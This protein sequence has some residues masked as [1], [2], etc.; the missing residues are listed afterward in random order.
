MNFQTMNKQRKWTLIAAAAGI[1]SIMLPFATVS[2]N[3]LGIESSQST[4][5]FH[6]YGIGVLLGYL[7]AIVLSLNGKQ[8]E[9]MQKSQWL[10][11]LAAGFI[12]LLFTVISMSIASKSVDGG[13]GLVDA[14]IG[15]GAWISLV[16]SV[17]L[18][19]SNW[20]NRQPEHEIKSSF[21]ELKKNFSGLSSPASTPAS[22]ATGIKIAE[23]ERLS[24]LKENGN[25]SEEEYQQLKS[26]LL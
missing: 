8:D 7:A 12:A 22:S 17:I 16:A 13:L 14:H 26:K 20:I 23:M 3:F 4:N 21:D 25:I 2:A 1:I 5:G 9:P 15:I 10:M 11:V 18:L 6:G 24:K 19:V